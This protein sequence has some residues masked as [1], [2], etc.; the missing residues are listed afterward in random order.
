[1]PSY[2]LANF[3]LKNTFMVESAIAPFIA[4]EASSAGAMY[5]A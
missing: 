2:S 1:M 3:S 4:E 5:W